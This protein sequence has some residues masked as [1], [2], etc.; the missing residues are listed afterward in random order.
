MRVGRERLVNI[1]LWWRLEQQLRNV[2]VTTTRAQI[3]GSFWRE[4]DP[5][6]RAEARLM[7]HI[8]SLYDAQARNATRARW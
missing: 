2:L 6:A 5:A 4:R 1:E 3:S 8:V 7:Q